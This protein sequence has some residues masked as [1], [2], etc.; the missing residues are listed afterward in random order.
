MFHPKKYGS[1]IVIIVVIIVFIIIKVPALG[2][3]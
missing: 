1:L 3:Q 2:Q